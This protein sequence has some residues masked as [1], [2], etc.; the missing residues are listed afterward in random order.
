MKKSIIEKTER[1]VLRIPSSSLE[2]IKCRFESEHQE[3]K[4]SLNKFLVESLNA[5]V[6]DKSAV[7]KNQVD[8]VTDVIFSAMEHIQNL[9]QDSLNEESLNLIIKQHGTIIS[10]LRGLCVHH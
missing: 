4:V 10:L 5:R 9:K 6:F 3:K 7:T 2:K 8:Q 1:V